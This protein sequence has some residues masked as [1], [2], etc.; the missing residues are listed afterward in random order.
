MV[1]E[2]VSALTP[3]GESLETIT[4][5]E[6]TVEL[7]MTSVG[8][9]V[10]RGGL[11][12]DQRLTMVPERDLSEVYYVLEGA[13]RAV[14][15]GRTLLVPAGGHMVVR[16]LR[17]PVT[18]TALR[19]T[20]FLYVSSRPQFHLMSAKFASLKRMAIDIEEKD[21]YTAGHCG[22][23][24]SLSYATG[25][26]LGLGAEALYHLDL[27]AF[28]H[29]VGK[30]GVPEAILNK[31]TKLEP[32]E[33]EIIK[34]H[35]TLGRELLEPTFLSCAGYVVEQHHERLDGSG[36]PYGLSGDEV[37]VE[38]SIVAVADT[39]DAMTTDRPYR[40]ALPTEAAF[41][42]LERYKGVYYPRE[43][44]RAFFEAVRANASS[45]AA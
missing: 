17:A 6:G 43:V 27:G 10:S 29:D 11:L 21:A 19:D 44:V 12:K 9:E 26:V 34:Q 40:R 31:P 20:T 5:P 38:A 45:Q 7:L 42:E 2:P 4:S 16:D 32:H 37:S 3:L 1:P 22:R 35:P 14:E 23:L 18:F 41:A 30:V 28:L 15:G 13:L 25:R 33:W 36:Y 24:Q 39:Y 8:A